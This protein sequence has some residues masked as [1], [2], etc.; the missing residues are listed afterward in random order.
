MGCHDLLPKLNVNRK[1][2]GS[3]KIEEQDQFRL[4]ARVVVPPF[5][6]RAKAPKG[7]TVSGFYHYR[8]P[9]FL[10]LNAIQPGVIV[11]PW[12]HSIISSWDYAMVGL[13]PTESPVLL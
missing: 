5:G 13:P 7:L 11:T 6:G 4:A 12:E 1:R 2:R 10:K 8:G 3:S 9:S